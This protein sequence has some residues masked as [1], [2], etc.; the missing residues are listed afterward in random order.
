MMNDDFC[1]S[2]IGNQVYKRQHRMSMPLDMN[3]SLYFEHPS[4]PFFRS[5]YNLHQ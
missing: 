2:I 1:I 4:P 5:V 3:V